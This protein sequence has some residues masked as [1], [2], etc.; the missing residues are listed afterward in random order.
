MLKNRDDLSRLINDIYTL[1]NLLV[2]CYCPIKR[3]NYYLELIDKIDDL[4]QFSNPYDL[5]DLR[6]IKL[7]TREELS[8]YN[9][10]NGMPAYVAVD[11]IIYDV[12]LVASFGGGTHFGVVAGKDLTK[13]FYDCHKTKGV[14]ESLTII[15]TLI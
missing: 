2:K 3:K 9:G 13:E 8:K 12:S 7:F 10:S 15:G 6:E 11:G 14:L 4:Y 1:K 5:S